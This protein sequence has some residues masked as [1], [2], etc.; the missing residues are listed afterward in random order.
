PNTVGLWTYAILWIM[1]LSAKINVYLGVTNH[2]A[3]FLPDE[4]A[5]LQSY[6]GK[7]PMNL[8]FPLSVTVSTVFVVWLF[9]AATAAGATPFETVGT[10]LLASLLALAVLEHWF[11]IIPLPATQLWAWGLVSHTSSRAKTASPT[12]TEINETKRSRS[13]RSA[14]PVPPPYPAG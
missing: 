1:R 4:V 3:E 9:T 11:L 10:A 5:Y 7:H 2:A 12:P 14:A 8:F 6:F 13:Q